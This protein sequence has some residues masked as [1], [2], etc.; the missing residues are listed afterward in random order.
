MSGVLGIASEGGEARDFARDVGVSSPTECTGGGEQAAPL[1]GP[2]TVGVCSGTK[3]SVLTATATA[4][5]VPKEGSVPQ[6]RVAPLLAKAGE[7]GEEA[8]S[9]GDC[10]RR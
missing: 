3:S 9:G 2:D 4:I 7:D 1:P 6:D 10:F 5:S 8:E